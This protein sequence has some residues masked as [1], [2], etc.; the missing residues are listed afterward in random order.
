MQMHCTLV[1]E[2]FIEPSYQKHLNMAHVNRSIY[3]HIG[4]CSACTQKVMEGK[5]KLRGQTHML[6][7][8]Q[9]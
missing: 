5:M 4:V 8:S 3:R 9:S 1:T 2:S 7:W 6:F